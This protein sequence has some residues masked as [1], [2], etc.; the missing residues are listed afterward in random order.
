V[1]IMEK[2]ESDL[3][4]VAV[5]RNA[6]SEMIVGRIG[7]GDQLIDTETETIEFLRSDRVIECFQ[8]PTGVRVS[9]IALNDRFDEVL[10]RIDYGDRVTFGNRS[11]RERIRVQMNPAFSILDGH[12]VAVRLELHRPSYKASVTS[13]EVEQ[14]LQSRVVRDESE[15]DAV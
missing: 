12:P 8:Y 11:S 10:G 14:P 6:D 3:V 15:L 1:E 4:I 7:I 2:V 9:W 13:F 5:Y